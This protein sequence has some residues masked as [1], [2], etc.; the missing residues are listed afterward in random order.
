MG[1]LVPIIDLKL[2]MFKNIKSGQKKFELKNWISQQKYKICVR[3][4]ISI[5]KKLHNISLKNI[6]E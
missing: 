6:V 3:A 2:K 5:T 1:Q 4:S